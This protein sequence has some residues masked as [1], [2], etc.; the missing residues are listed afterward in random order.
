MGGAFVTRTPLTSALSLDEDFV[1][2]AELLAP[3][4]DDEVRECLTALSRKANRRRREG[5]WDQ[6]G[7]VRADTRAR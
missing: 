5:W 6:Y 4:L 1:S 2:V 3:R 7:D